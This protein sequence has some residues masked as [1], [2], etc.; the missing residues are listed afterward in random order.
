MNRLVLDSF[1]RFS[2]KYW[3]SNFARV[4][5]RLF[6]NPSR[7]FGNQLLSNQVALDQRCV[8]CNVRRYF[9]SLKRSSQGQFSTKYVHVPSLYQI[10][11]LLKRE[12]VRQGVA[13]FFSTS[14]LRRQGDQ[15]DQNQQGD[16]PN[17]DELPE[18][19][20]GWVSFLPW[21]MLAIFYMLVAGS[22]SVPETTWSTF[23]REMLSIGE[24]EHLEV[25]SSQDKIFVFLHKGAVVG[26]KEIMSRGPHFVLQHCKP[27]QL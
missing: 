5:T 4:P 2:C 21:L 7:Y 24:V 25:P 10:S 20:G 9:G 14:H 15:E 19:Q 3:A 22:D 12:D 18:N 1:S 11:L 23:Y 17:P 8:Q 26:G 13:R 27:G 16:S 6:H